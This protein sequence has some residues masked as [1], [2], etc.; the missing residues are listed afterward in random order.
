MP[1]NGSGS[2]SRAVTPPVNGDVAD[3]DLFNDEMDD[4]ATALTNSLAR[5]GEAVPT[6]NLPMGGFKHTGLAA[7]SANGD[8]V[9][10]EQIQDAT[11]A[12]CQ[13]RLT[14]TTAVPVTISDVTAA[15]TLYFTPYL[16]NRIALYDGSNYWAARSF[17]EISI[18]LAGLTQ[19]INYD[20]FL[21]DNAGA[22]AARS[23]VAWT[24]STTRATAL[25]TQNG[26][27]VKSGATTDRYV[28]TIRMTNT[29]QTE[30]SKAK[31]FVWNMYN[32]RVRFM[33]VLPIVDSY[34]YTTATIRQMNADT[35]NQ[36]DFVRGLD[37]DAVA[38]FGVQLGTNSTAGVGFRGGIGLD[39]TNAFN[40][41]PGLAVAPVSGYTCEIA[42][43][44]NGMPGIG[45]HFLSLNEVSVASGTTTWYGDN[46][47]PTIF[48]A[49]ITGEVWA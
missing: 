3:A 23:P 15:T 44:Y 12:L 47:S 31:R 17:S 36:L 42:S 40:G 25:T 18:S 37:E 45:R 2:Y 10:Y 34:A 22:A 6:A 21:Y 27:P 20:I 9:R 32:R 29:G 39:A 16:G 48:Q 14:L 1:R 19:D 5:N 4:I 28:G 46:G 8:S 49:G 35:A 13:G 33:Q 43:R 30:D 26:V 41:T 24:N 11:H 7:G 38:A